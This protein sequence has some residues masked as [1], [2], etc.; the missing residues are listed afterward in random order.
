MIPTASS[1]DQQI[2]AYG[3]LTRN[4]HTDILYFRMVASPRRVSRQIRAGGPDFRPND[5]V[6]QSHTAGRLVN[7]WLTCCRSPRTKR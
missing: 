5:D 4:T 7:G 6:T 3:S 1:K 2:P